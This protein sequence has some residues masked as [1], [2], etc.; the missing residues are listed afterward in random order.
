MSKPRHLGRQ[1][2]F[3][4]GAAA[5]LLAFGGAP[6]AY[7]GAA[8]VQFDS[9]SVTSSFAV[10]GVNGADV[11]INCTVFA[12]TEAHS[13]NQT[14]PSVLGHGW[15]ACS[16][17][18]DTRKIIT[19]SN[20]TTRLYNASTGEHQASSATPCA[21]APTSANC[22]AVV[23]PMTCDAD[24]AGWCNDAFYTYTEGIIT[25]NKDIDPDSLTTGCALLNSKTMRCSGRNAGV[26]V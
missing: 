13:N 21:N 18:A 6:S 14:S 11:V 20:V 1:I 15:L 23:G 3:A 26:R 5:V 12:S 8:P 22:Q 4:A 16:G 19:D 25:T 7:A 10:Y 24:S 17:P 9:S 2:G